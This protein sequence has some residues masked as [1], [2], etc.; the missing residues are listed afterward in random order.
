VYRKKL[1]T[2]KVNWHVEP[3]KRKTTQ[4]ES[5]ICPSQTRQCAPMSAAD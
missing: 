5:L 4:T 2:P 1:L 3:L